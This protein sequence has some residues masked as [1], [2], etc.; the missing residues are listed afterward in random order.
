MTCPCRDGSWI[1]EFEFEMRW[2]VGLAP[3]SLR[4]IGYELRKWRAWLLTRQHCWHS[5]GPAEL[6]QWLAVAV[7]TR[8][9]ST[10]DL[11]CWVLGRL[12][13]WGM[14]TGRLEIDP[15]RELGT[16]A[17][18]RVWTPRYTPTKRDVETLLSQPDTQTM[19]GIRDRAILELLYASGIR[20]SEL[21]SLTWP[22]VANG[23]KDRCMPIIGKGQRER[24]VI[25]GDHAARWM[26]LYEQIARR[27][28]LSKAG[29]SSQYFVQHTASGELNYRQ[30][31]RI[32]QRHAQAAELPLLTAHSL[33]HAFATHL[34]Q[35][36][37]NLRLIQMLLGHARLETTTI[38]AKTSMNQLRELI[39]HH[40]P[41]GIHYKRQLFSR[42]EWRSPGGRPRMFPSFV[43][44]SIPPIKTIKTSQSQ[45]THQKSDMTTKIMPT[46][47]KPRCM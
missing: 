31:H 1:A 14:E 30:L 21:I 9:A 47:I 8:A 44:N 20:A 22:Q 39:E 32:V 19:S 41:R 42:E 4:C 7:N 16:P 38:Y 26:R 37:A 12:Y 2:G 34:Y 46:M 40:H 28:L 29:T 3:G 23:S 43:T 13:R 18:P 36:G 27:R 6:R 15:W 35:A 33:R 5:V 24:L 45:P 11:R 25:Y 10:V 17:R